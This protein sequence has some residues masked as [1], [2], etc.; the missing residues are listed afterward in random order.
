M[1][2]IVG[3]HPKLLVDQK[4]EVNSPNSSLFFRIF[5]FKFVKFDMY[6]LKAIL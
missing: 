1:R 3:N 2:K 5:F 4:V 6:N